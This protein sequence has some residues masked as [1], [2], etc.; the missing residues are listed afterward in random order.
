MYKIMKN[1]RIETYNW[2]RTKKT[3][4]PQKLK[5]FVIFALVLILLYIGASFGDTCS[6]IYPTPKPENLPSFCVSTAHK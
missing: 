1:Q 6:G 4:Q 3:K 2:L 5:T